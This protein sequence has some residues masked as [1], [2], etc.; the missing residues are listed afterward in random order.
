MKNIFIFFVAI[1]L[2]GCSISK[3]HSKGAND[4]IVLFGSG[5][6]NDTVSLHIDNKQIFKDRILQSD[7]VSGI[8][9]SV[10]IVKK[11]NRLSLLNSKNESMN[12]MDFNN[13]KEI[14]VVI[15]INHKP[16]KLAVSLNKG[17]IIMVNSQSFYNKVNIS[18][19]KKVIPLD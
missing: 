15:E 17:Y 2:A 16:H 4:F 13:S 9:R 5:F 12:V 7:T 11:N 8:V 19:N 6:K 14:I 18:Q 1:I 3:L 10:S